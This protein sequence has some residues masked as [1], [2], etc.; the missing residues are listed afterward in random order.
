[1]KDIKKQ[2]EPKYDIE[3]IIVYIII[4]IGS[5]CMIIL[6]YTMVMDLSHYFRIHH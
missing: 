6:L 5:V 1:M 2:K 3:N 4:G